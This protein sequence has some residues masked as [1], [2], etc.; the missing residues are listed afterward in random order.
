VLVVWGAVWW[1]VVVLVWS[2]SVVV[3]VA[4]VSVVAVRL[5]RA[6]ANPLEMSFMPDASAAMID[7]A[8][9]LRSAVSIASSG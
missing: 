4:V 7:D 2:L 9:L 1:V 8:I 5:I 6:S 3:A